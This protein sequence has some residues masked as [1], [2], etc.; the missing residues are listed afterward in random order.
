MNGIFSL[1]FSY[2]F[3]LTKGCQKG[4]R[5]KGTEAQSLKKGLYV[6]AK[7]PVKDNEA[8]PNS[9]LLFDWDRE[10]RQAKMQSPLNGL[11]PVKRVRQKMPA[12]LLL[13]ILIYLLLFEG[14][15]K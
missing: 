3:I 11:R 9:L 2:R 10:T 13:P 4:Q 15:K 12:V 7:R 14:T 5:F 1:F 6:I 8:I